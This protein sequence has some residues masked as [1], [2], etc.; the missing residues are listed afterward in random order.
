MTNQ[1]YK[2]YVSLRPGQLADIRQ[3]SP[4]SALGPHIHSVFLAIEA[5]R[6]MS[7]KGCANTISVDNW[8]ILEH[9]IPSVR[10]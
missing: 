4:I 2:G 3:W 8:L 6:Y 1:I 7:I 5:H 9:L 10:R